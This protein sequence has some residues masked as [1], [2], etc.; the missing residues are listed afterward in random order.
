MQKVL[1]VDDSLSVRKVV[2]KA[3]EGRGLHVLSAASGAEAIETI[4]RDRPD[5][6]ICDVI[7]PDKDGYQICQYVRTHP[8]ISSTPVLL[9]SG[10]DNGTVQARAAEV[11]SN[12]VMFKPF[13][14][15]DLVRKIDGLLGRANG[16]TLPPSAIPPRASNSAPAAAPKA[17]SP[18]AAAP[19]SRDDAR[20]GGALKQRLAALA[21]TPGVRFAVLTDREGFLIETVGDLTPDTD[22]V[23][24]A[25][26]SCLAEASE[27]LGLELY[28][29]GV[30]VLHARGLRATPLLAAP[31]LVIPALVIPPVFYLLVGLV[32]LRPFS[33]RRVLGAAVAMCGLHALLVAATGA[34]YTISDLLD[35]GSAV[36]FALWGS[37]AVTLLQLTAA[38]LVF[39]RL[40]PLLSSPRPAPRAEARATP[41]RRAEVPGGAAARAPSI[42][43][44][45]RVPAVSSSAFARGVEPVVASPSVPQPV[46]TPAAPAPPAPP[47]R[48]L[49][50][51]ET[52]EPMIRISFGRIADQLPLEMF[53]RGREGLHATLR[54]GVSLLVPRRL[55]L[56]YLGEALAPVKWEVVADQFP[57][58]EL[59]LSHEEIAGR[60]PHRSLLLPLDEVV[61]Q[62]PAELLA[63]STPAADVFGIEEFPPPFQPHVP[64]P[65]ET[66]AVD[67]RAPA[68][69]AAAAV[70]EPEPPPVSESREEPEPPAEPE[71]SAEPEGLTEPEPVAEPELFVE[72]LAPAEPELPV[73][74]EP[75]QPERGAETLADRGRTAE[76]RRIAALLAPLMNGL[77]I[78]ERDG[79]GTTL[80]TVVAPT[81]REDSVARTAARVVP[82]LA[83][84]RLSDPVAQATLTGAEATIVLTPFGSSGAGGALLVTAVRSRAS[85]AWLE[86]LSRSAAGEARVPAENGGHSSPVGN[87][88]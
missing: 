73:E 87:P 14:L 56:P 45:R 2:E 15:D 64:P 61:P 36:A 42:P 1:V 5:V 63:L 18:T 49:V 19:G 8:A 27:G 31:S 38:P 35:F 16:S 72:P 21:G 69:P 62:I 3:L 55:L 65:S 12:E 17:P 67:T 79:A 40:R 26:A 70:A 7:L 52:G 44:L 85:L 74:E 50:R 34:L 23:A 86:R 60:L 20:D 4:E 46:V 57:R 76:A 82:F 32:S 71:A 58:D 66:P 41:R 30:L 80:V 10:I 25:L 51:P 48:A 6:V 13:G 47:T 88:A 77:E 78:G 33:L 68:E 28:A 22:E 43:P 29:C 39:A 59:A 11:R 9:I 81:L 83:D 53:A 84:A 37:P 54:P 24:G 75:P